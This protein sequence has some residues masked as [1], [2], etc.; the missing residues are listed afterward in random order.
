MKNDTFST[1]KRPQVEPMLVM[2]LSPIAVL[3]VQVAELLELHLWTHLRGFR[4]PRQLEC[5]VRA[6]FWYKSHSVH[7]Q[8][9]L[10][11]DAL[12]GGLKIEQIFR[13]QCTHAQRT[14]FRRSRGITTDSF[15]KVP[16]HHYG[17]IF[18][19]PEA[20]PAHQNSRSGFLFFN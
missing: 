14:H 8:N 2:I 11:W 1:W 18:E 15:S 20:Y 5:S 17:F 12:L 4:R 7:N 19:G 16:R 13:K 10:C 9:D 3:L 6:L